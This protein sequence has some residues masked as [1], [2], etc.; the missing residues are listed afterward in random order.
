M[1]TLVY[2][3]IDQEGLITQALLLGNVEAAVELS[4]EAKRFTDAIIIA[5]TGKNVLIDVEFKK[6]IMLIFVCRRF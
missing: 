2:V 4:L 1:V 3:F 5:M 6:I